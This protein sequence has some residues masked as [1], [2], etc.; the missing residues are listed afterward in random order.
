MA[1]E[2]RIVQCV[3]EILSEKDL[4]KNSVEYAVAYEKLFHVV[5]DENVTKV[6]YCEHKQKIV[7]E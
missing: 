7:F 2:S 5:K 3:H 1:N 6:E 4:I